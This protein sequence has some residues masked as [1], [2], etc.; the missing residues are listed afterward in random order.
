M[1][2]LFQKVGH[3][4]CYGNVSPQHIPKIQKEHLRPSAKKKA[5]SPRQRGVIFVIETGSKTE[6]W[7]LHS[8]DGCWKGV[9][10][11]DENWLK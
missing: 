5:Q 4:E 6:P 10:C 2:Q 8:V 3:R 7:G 1:V 9:I 11:F